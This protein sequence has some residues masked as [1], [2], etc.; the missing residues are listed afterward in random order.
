MKLIRATWLAA[1]LLAF[2]APLQ[3]QTLFGLIPDENPQNGR[4]AYR[5][6]VRQ[7]VIGLLGSW[8]RAWDADNTRA[9]ADL[10]TRDGLFVGPAGDEVQSR[11]SLRAKLEA[12]FAGAG[13]LRYSVT[14]FDFSGEM[15]YMRGQMAYPAGSAAASGESKI[16]T[17]ILVAR[18]QRD[19]VWL[20]RSLTLVPLAAA[21]AAP[22]AAAAPTAP[23]TPVAPP[24]T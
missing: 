21:P 6:R 20:I 13:A 2:A 7:E 23:P 8:K 18:R 12:V 3:A 10:Y 16:E 9:A 15:A 24:G 11:D 1:A 14:D 19:D 17:F 4:E 22:P 5:L